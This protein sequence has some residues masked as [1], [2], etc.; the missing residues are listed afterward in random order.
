MP[1][2]EFDILGGGVDGHRGVDAGLHPLRVRRAGG[3]RGPPLPQVQGSHGHT[4]QQGSAIPGK[5]CISKKFW[6]EFYSKLRLGQDLLDIHYDDKESAQSMIND[7]YLN[8]S[9]P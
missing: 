6:P 7:S 9:Y 8:D 5:Y 2:K 1:S 4:A 3:V